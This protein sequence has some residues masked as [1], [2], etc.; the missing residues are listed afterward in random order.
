MA[1]LDDAALAAALAGLAW[2]RQG[3][4]LVK[5]TK[6]DGFGGALAYVNAVGAI[7]ESADHHPDIDIRWDTVT[8]RLST[9]S[10]GGLT[11]KDVDVA[12]AIDQIEGTIS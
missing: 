12:A 7:A 8:L 5:V 6:H 10:E 11:Q 4:Q 2:T 1:L 9:H 3:D